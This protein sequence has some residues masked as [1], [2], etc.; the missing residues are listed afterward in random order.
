VVGTY[1]FECWGSKGY[2]SRGN[3]DPGYGAYTKGDL[4]ITMG[5]ICTFYV[6]VGTEGGNKHATVMAR[7][8]AGSGEQPGGG[9]TDIR[10]INSQD[11]AGWKSR[12]MVAGGGGGGF[13]HLE[14][15]RVSGDA[16]GITGYDASSTGNPSQPYSQGGYGASQTAG[17][18]HGDMTQ[19][20][21]DV[22]HTTY[23]DGVFFR[24]GYSIGNYGNG[25]GSPASGGGG[26]YYGGGY[27]IHPGG[28]HKGGGGGSSFISGH[29]GCN[30]VGSNATIDDRH[31]T[32]SPN[33]YSGYIF[34]SGTTVMIDGRG[35]SWTD[36]TTKTYTKQPQP[37]GTETDGHG[38]SGYARITET[39]IE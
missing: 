29:T 31:H 14:S 10:L 3:N 2:G 16:G 18:A 35:Y 19:Y 6:Y 34:N 20:A 7:N 32:G 17:G 4:T 8:G 11:F 13:Y 38:A 36:A 39:F 1:T 12:I 33:H 37:D 23:G 9:G 25:D 26:G 30:A 24:G 27:G 22:D 5:N 28:S 15:N 21:G